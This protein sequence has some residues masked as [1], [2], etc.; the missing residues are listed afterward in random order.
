[1]CQGKA[2]G[3]ACLKKALGKQQ[4]SGMGNTS[5]EGCWHLARALPQARTQ[6]E[7]QP[8]WSSA[9]GCFVVSWPS[10]A[11][12]ASPPSSEIFFLFL[13]VFKPSTWCSVAENVPPRHS[14]AHSPV[15]A[16]IKEEA[17]LSGEGSG[18]VSVLTYNF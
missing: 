5:K 9:P 10:P 8:G 7:P 18:V 4:R 15:K 16:G 6:R 11:G 3:R 2:G 17:E 12:A 13:S 14:L 1:M